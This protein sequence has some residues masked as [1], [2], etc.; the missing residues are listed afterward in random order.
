MKNIDSISNILS[1]HTD[2]DRNG[3]SNLILPNFFPD[4]EVV[5]F[6]NSKTSLISGVFDFIANTT[7]KNILICQ[8]EE[9]SLRINNRDLK[10][11]ISK[12]AESHNKN[13]K[14][15]TNSISDFYESNKLMDVSYRPGILDIICHTD[16]LKLKKLNIEKI[17]FHTAFVYQNVNPAR[18][19]TINLINDNN[20][21][22][23]F[24]YIKYPA[25]NIRIENT[26]LKL[27]N[28]FQ[29]LHNGFFP[30]APYE[31]YLDLE[32]SEHIAFFTEV[33]SLND[34]VYAPT[35]SE[36]TFR[37]IHLM[38]P[39]LIFG[40]LNT[41]QRLQDLG[42]DTWDWLI[43]WSFDK[44]SDDYLRHDLFLEE[45]Q[46]L[47]NLDLDY[48]KKLLNENKDKLIYNRNRVLDLI[49]NY[50]DDSYFAAAIE[51]RQ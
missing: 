14:L 26:N 8:T 45:L 3:I 32:W 18:D 51:H 6:I 48:I 11:K 30:D 43:D 27:N 29:D 44:E 33:E 39:A 40:G 22:N 2:C 5:Y 31:S 13:V 15:I 42:F 25:Y 16:F 34:T 19:K 23:K 50:A 21:E 9:D 4:Y 37:A 41:R 38:R 36:K 1:E 35:L 17:N 12:F 46:R 7:E 47:L 10:L 28:K 24:V 20:L 49:E